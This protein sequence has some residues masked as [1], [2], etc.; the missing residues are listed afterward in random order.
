MCQPAEASGTA[1]TDPGL[2][3]KTGCSRSLYR[4]ERQRS[5]EDLLVASDGDP[6]SS[7]DLGEPRFVGSIVREMVVVS[8][9]GQTRGFE[10]F[11]EDMSAQVAVDEENPAQATLS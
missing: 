5:P 7:R 10:G 8:L 6:F 9:D 11:G 4:G 3:S 2:P 1:F